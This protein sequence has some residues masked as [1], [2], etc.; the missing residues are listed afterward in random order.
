MAIERNNSFHLML[1]D[2]E[3]ALLKMLAEQKGLNASDYLRMLI[4]EG[5]RSGQVA[6][7]LTLG[8]LLEKGLDL[9]ESWEKAKAAGAKT[10]KR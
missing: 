10:K 6:Q 9:R 8:T 4:R 1:S 3:L 2:D 7:L 5:D